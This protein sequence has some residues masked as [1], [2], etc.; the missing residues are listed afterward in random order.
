MNLHDMTEFMMNSARVWQWITVT[1]GLL[2]FLVFTKAAKLEKRLAKLQKQQAEPSVSCPICEAP[3]SLS[4]L[5]DPEPT[6]ET[7]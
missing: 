4:D 3:H 2:S 5:L 6:I 1:M 7:R